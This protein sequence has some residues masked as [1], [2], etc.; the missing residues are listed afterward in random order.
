VILILEAELDERESG[1]RATPEPELEQIAA[2][3]IRTLSVL[4][5]HM[6]ATFAR[7]VPWIG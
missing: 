7:L 4:V 1:Y 6:S 3:T 2:F 5:S